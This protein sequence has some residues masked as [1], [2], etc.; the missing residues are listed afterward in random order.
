[1][2]TGKSCYCYTCERSNEATSTLG[3]D[4]VNFETE[5]TW[6]WP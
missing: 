2:V 3:D 1:M 6:L 4:T 5:E